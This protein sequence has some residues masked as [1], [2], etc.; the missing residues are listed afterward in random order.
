MALGATGGMVSRMVVSQG[1]KVVIAGV[2]VGVVVAVLSTRLL[3]TLLFGVDAVSPAVFAAVSAM[4]ILV[5]LLAS[6]IP[7]RRASRVNPIA[8]L[9]LE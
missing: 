6:Y 7:A 1:A 8:S 2:V 3:N 9:R 5:G 4:M